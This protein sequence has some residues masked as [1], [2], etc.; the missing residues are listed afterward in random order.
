MTQ[1]ASQSET[2]FQQ[3][4]QRT[5]AEK[6]M[7][8]DEWQQRL[9]IQLE[10][11]I[12]PL[13]TGTAR[14]ACGD[15]L[16]V[17]GPPGRGKT[18]IVDAFFHWAPLQQKKRVHF[19]LFFRELH[20]MIAGGRSV[21]AAIAASIGDCQLLC[22][23]EFHLH[24]IGDA[25]LIK[26]LLAQ[27]FRCGVLLVAT[28]N[29]PPENLL[30]NPLYHQ[31]FVPCIELMR[32]HM[33][34]VA[35]TGENDYRRRRRQ[36]HEAFSAGAMLPPGAGAWRQRLAL[37]VPAAA[38]LALTVGYRTLQVLSPAQEV[39]HFSF[40]ALCEAPTA[41]MD[42]LTLSERYRRWLL[43]D[44]PPLGGVSPAAQQRFINLIDVLYDRS[45]Q[46]F[47]TTACSPSELTQDVALDDIQRTAS[48]LALLPRYPQPA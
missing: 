44:V 6:A 41:V 40:H 16:Y 46:L 30:A 36:P 48:R 18:F 25:M 14:G 7:V 27:L 8:L 31:R 24:D 1:P 15:G 37:P 43:E 17:W 19:H 34:L 12:A 2:A 39:L 32:Q 35:L 29:H 28:S 3:L 23:D 47:I 26:P 22:F 45:C 42:Y 38:P 9:I 20:Q 5:A 11:L 10:T 13:L 33:T 21:E 4:M